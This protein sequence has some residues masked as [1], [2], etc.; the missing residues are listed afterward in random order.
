MRRYLVTHLGNVLGCGLLRSWWWQL[1]VVGSFGVYAL[2]NNAGEDRRSSDTGAEVDSSDSDVADEDEWEDV[3]ATDGPIELDAVDG[4]E[5]DDGVSTRVV[6]PEPVYAGASIPGA[7]PGAGGPRP[8]GALPFPTV[9]LGYEYATPLFETP[10]G[11]IGC[12]IFDQRLGCGVWSYIHD[13]LYP[14]SGYGS[15]VE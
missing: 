14:L 3:T 10:S 1:F 6:D 4:D 13:R 2:L 12:E 11:N 7:Y 5:G 8:D 15:D 9:N